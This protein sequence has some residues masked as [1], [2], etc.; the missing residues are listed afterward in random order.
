MPNGIINFFAVLGFIYTVIGVPGL[1]F[2][3]L[4]IRNAESRED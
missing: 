3:L 1:V 4:T 2:I